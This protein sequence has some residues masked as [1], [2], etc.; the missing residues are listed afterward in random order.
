MD[1]LEEFIGSFVTVLIISIPVVFFIFIGYMLAD[2]TIHKELIKKGCGEY[3]KTTGKFYI[4]D[5]SKIKAN[6]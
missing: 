1:W 4:K 6:K 5:F 3:N 2:S